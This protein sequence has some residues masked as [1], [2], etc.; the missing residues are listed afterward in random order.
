MLFR[1]RLGDAIRAEQIASLAGDAAAGRRLFF[2]VAAVQCKNCHRIEGQGLEIG[3]DL[4][5]IGKKY[6][7]A[8]LLETILEPSKQVDPKYVAYLVETADGQVH[9][10]LLV[11]RTERELV[12][13]DGQ[14]KLIRIP[15]AEAELVAPQQ[16]SLMPELLLR[17][18]TAQEAAD[19]LEFLGTLKGP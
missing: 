19:L 17:E 8:Q 2:E 10:G 18:M 16:K 12:L 15:T 1:S 13:R 14:N 3:P 6:N 4:S 7:R 11:E 5:Q 9:T